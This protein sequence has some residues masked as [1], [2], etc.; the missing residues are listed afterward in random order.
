[1]NTSGLKN[2]ITSELFVL[3]FLTPKG[4]ICYAD[5]LIASSNFRARNSSTLNKYSRLFIKTELPALIDIYKNTTSGES[6]IQKYQIALNSFLNLISSPDT[7]M[8]SLFEILYKE[9]QLDSDRIRQLDEL[10]LQKKNKKKEKHKQKAK[11][12]L[13]LTPEQREQKRI[14]E[15]DES[16]RGLV[17]MLS[18]YD[19]SSWRYEWNIKVSPEYREYSYYHYWDGPFVLRLYNSSKEPSV[20]LQDRQLQITREEA[21][22]IMQNSIKPSVEYHQLHSMH[23]PVNTI[24][25]NH[26]PFRTTYENSA[27]FFHLKMEDF[28]VRQ[29]GFF[30]MRNGH[31]V[32]DIN[33]VVSIIDLNG[34]LNYYIINAA[35]CPQCNVYFILNSV[36]EYLKTKGTILCRICDSQTYYS[37]SFSNEFASKESILKQYG[38]NV[39]KIN[40][41]PD[42]TRHMILNNLVANNILTKTTIISYLDLFICQHKTQ[43][44]CK[45]A[46]EKWILDRKFVENIPNYSTDLY[47]IHSITIK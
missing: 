10:A 9:E 12:I 44:N 14:R 37:G 11:P 28:V 5:R 39:N 19:Y 31:K 22:L 16:M 13:P 25:V 6:R 33:V 43:T 30:C 26:I 38:Y 32:T 3:R 27:N 29:F 34:K 23:I 7:D 42:K 21:M 18:K 17:S 2:I 1:M 20:F 41:I 46:V 15:L 40:N 47:G 8:D 4:K 35:Y 45:N 36:Y 24:P